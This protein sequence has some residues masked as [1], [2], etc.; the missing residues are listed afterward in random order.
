[1]LDKILT[2][3]IL[4]LCFYIFWNTLWIWSMNRARRKGL[5][6]EKGKATLFDVRKLLVNGEK[7]MAI[8][9]YCEIFKV[10]RR[11]AK[12]AIEQLEKNIQP[13]NSKRE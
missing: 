7:D 6:P 12:K 13:K 4:I 11:E 1:M 2:V 10:S 8:V 9:V 5:Y 3:I